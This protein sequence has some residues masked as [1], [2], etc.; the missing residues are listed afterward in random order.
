MEHG[1]KDIAFYVQNIFSTVH[2]CHNFPV[3]RVYYFQISAD[4][5]ESF[6]PVI[7]ALA[8]VKHVGK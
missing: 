5:N 7:D 1:L 4:D 3:K 6:K 2:S 8:A